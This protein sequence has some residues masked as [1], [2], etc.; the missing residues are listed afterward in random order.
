MKEKIHN[1]LA[2]IFV[3]VLG[4]AFIGGV[5]WLGSGATGRSYTVYVVYMTESVAGLS[6]DGA[7]KYKGVD[8]GFVRK[9]GLDPENP[10]RVRLELEIEKHTPI[11]VDTV[12]TLEVQGLTGLAFVNLLNSSQSAEHL[13]RKDGERYPVIPSRPSVWG[14]LD[15]KLMELLDELTDG[16]RQIKNLLSTEN[17][18]LLVETLTHLRDLSAVLAERSGSIGAGVDDLTGTL[19]ETR[20]ASERLPGLIDRLQQAAVA[21]EKMAAEVGATSRV[22]T[23]VVTARNR[24]L[25][26]FTSTTLPEASATVE[27]LRQ[28]AE[29]L[30][31]LSESLARD[32]SVLLL[33]APPPRPG[34]GE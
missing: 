2:G 33:G 12:A 25:Q 24:D 34:P 4:I 30:R 5:L 26:R 16:S 10:E 9:I 27:E 31:E 13:K 19:R 28:A 18:A 32:P 20:K 8:V 15:K 21:L 17:Q 23:N 22:V 29:N 6:R 14:R 1:I 7:V 3:L 11:K